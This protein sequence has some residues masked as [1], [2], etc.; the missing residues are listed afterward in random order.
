MDLSGTAE[1]NSNLAMHLKANMKKIR[2]K[3]KVYAVTAN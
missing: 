3:T 1:S 2:E